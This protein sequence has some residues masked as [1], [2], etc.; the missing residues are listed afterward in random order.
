M[1][2][3]AQQPGIKQSQQFRLSNE[4]IKRGLALF[5]GRIR[6]QQRLD[7]IAGSFNISPGLVKCSI[8]LRSGALQCLKSIENYTGTPSHELN[9]NLVG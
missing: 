6:T 5:V 3:E 4:F 2:A 9:S 1:V 7:L 8:D